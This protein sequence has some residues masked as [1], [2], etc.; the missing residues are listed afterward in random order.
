MT[1][2]DLIAEGRKLL[3]AATASPWWIS[4]MGDI[5]AGDGSGDSPAVADVA[6]RSD[7][8]L[9]VWMR[10]N[11]PAVLDALEAAH[12]YAVDHEGRCNTLCP[13]CGVEVG[14]PEANAQAQRPPLGYVV[15]A[16]YPGQAPY[17]RSADIHAALTAAQAEA[18]AQGS[19]RSGK[20]RY[21]VAEL[22]EASGG[23][24]LQERETDQGKRAKP[25]AAEQEEPDHA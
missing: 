4:G 23:C 15:L 14:V 8:E 17:L 11:L 6:E 25:P 2:L 24:D 16:H 1:E 13:R 20:W 22:R 7:A 3:A 18:D 21:T 12:S 19:G 9:I 10:N 5:Y